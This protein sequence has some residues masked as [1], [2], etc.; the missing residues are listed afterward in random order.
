MERIG[1][2]SETR[3]YTFRDTNGATYIGSPGE[4]FGGQ[5]KLI[6]GPTRAAQDGE[7]QN[8]V[9]AARALTLILAPY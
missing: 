4:E 2:D 8:F 9:M 5:L 3:R 7:Y 1:Y 6:S